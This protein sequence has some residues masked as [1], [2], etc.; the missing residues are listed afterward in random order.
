MTTRAQS[1]SDPSCPHAALSHGRAEQRAICDHL[2]LIADQ[3]GGP[4]DRQ[5]CLSTLDRLAN[6]LPLYHADEEALFDILGARTQ[7]EGLVIRCIDQVAHD[8]RH[9]QDYTLEIADSLEDYLTNPK[10]ANPDA[11]GYMLRCAF[12]GLRQH[13]AWEDVTLLGPLLRPLTEQEI[14]Q[15][16]VRSAR[17][18]SS[19][20]RYI[21]I[22]DR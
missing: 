12:E 21:R 9:Y 4:I 6:E 20:P 11:L 10:T 13:M 15:F 18:R 19:R 3:L 2:E 17:N 1:P 8:H 22:A 14:E 5:L 7:P 16:R